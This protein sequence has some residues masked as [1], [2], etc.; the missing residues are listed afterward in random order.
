MLSL[1]EVQRRSFSC[2]TLTLL[3]CSRP[4]STLNVD[5]QKRPSRNSGKGFLPETLVRASFQRW[6]MGAV[7][8]RDRGERGSLKVYSHRLQWRLPQRRVQAAWEKG[9]QNPP[10]LCIQSGEGLETRRRALL[11]GDGSHRCVEG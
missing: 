3:L 6:K 10:T 9:I 2:P 5:S 7:V 11:G 1:E 4:P 8:W